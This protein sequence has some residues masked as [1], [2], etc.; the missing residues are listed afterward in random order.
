M[1]S[2]FANYLVQM[3]G[4]EESVSAA[5]VPTLAVWRFPKNL[6]ANLL[7]NTAIPLPNP[8]SGT[9]YSQQGC[10]YNIHSSQEMEETSCPTDGIIK[11]LQISTVEYYSAL[12]KS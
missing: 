2:L 3:Q 8:H 9:L 5:G 10:L 12:K 1:L 6:E 4:K 11:M 7:H